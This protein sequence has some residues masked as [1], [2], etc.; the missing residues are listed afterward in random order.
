MIYEE[1]HLMQSRAYELMSSARR[2]QAVTLAHMERLTSLQLDALR[3]YS[4]LATEQLR[5]ALTFFDA[6]GEQ[7][8]A[9]GRLRREPARE[10]G[11]TGVTSAADAP[12]AGD[13]VIDLERAR[14][15]AD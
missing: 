12:T 3:A 4:G 5:A 11:D 13:N 7:S 1:F 15:E 8:P 2:Y 9:T 6:G 10:R 14:S